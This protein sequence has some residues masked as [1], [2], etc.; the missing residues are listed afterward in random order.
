MPW[1]TDTLP[2]DHEMY[3]CWFLLRS[4][5]GCLMVAGIWPLLCFAPND[6][7]LSHLT[8]RGTTVCRHQRLVFWG[9]RMLWCGCSGAESASNVLPS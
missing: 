4:A 2:F 9:E 1:E 7:F 6:V 8:P 5:L 3:S